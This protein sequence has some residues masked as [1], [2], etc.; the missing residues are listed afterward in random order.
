MPLGFIIYPYLFYLIDNKKFTNQ[1]RIVHF[2]SGFFYGFG[3][4]SIILIWIKEP[5]LTN[6]QT[7]S[8]AFLSYLLIIYYSLYFGL[9]FLFIKYFKNSFSKLITFPAIIVLNEIICGNVSYGFPWISYALI[10]SSNKFGLSIIYY[11]GNYGLSY[12]TLFIFL[13]PA[14][15]LLP[16]SLKK[17]SIYKFYVFLYFIIFLLL[18]FLILVRLFYSDINYSRNI[19]VS[20]VQLNFPI[21]FNISNSDLKLRELA[22]IEK[23]SNNNN[24]ILIFAENNYPYLINEKSDISYFNK[25]TYF[26]N[27]V[28]LGLNRKNNNAI[29]NSMA[30]IEK[31]KIEIFDKKI[32]VPFGEFVPFRKYLG[33]MDIIAG[34]KDFT[35]GSNERIMQT[36]NNVSII[37]VICYEII[38]FWKLF[39]NQNNKADI[40]VN[41][42]NDAWFG[43][44]SGPYQHF[45]L[46]RLRAA[47][48]NKP[49]IRVSNNGV[50][51]AI[52]NMGNI[53]GYLA[54]NK[55]AVGVFDIK[56]PENKKNFLKFHH[57]VFYFI[58]LVI[59]IG[60]FLNKKNESN[61]I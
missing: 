40:I 2:L 37:P 38:F 1:S 47:E 19:K 44:L 58:F 26:D 20:L 30:L 57:F 9:T 59:L 28:I 22:I 15:F 25:Q 17:R 53:I 7:Q 21:N 29:Y 8:F 12:L 55:S 61:I 5:F 36:K 46:A 18:L 32:L 51:A 13:F 23:I 3:F 50:S 39:N 54:L 41:I 6:A 11:I 48:S 27:S 43:N 24:E 35:I 4:A 52:D 16:K 10:H 34:S 33:F 14:I 60:I 56:I 49:L 31:N 45:Y 42:T